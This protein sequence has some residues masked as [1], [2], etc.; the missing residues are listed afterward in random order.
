[1]PPGIFLF[2]TL[3]KVDAQAMAIARG[4]DDTVLVSDTSNHRVQRFDGRGKLL[5]AIGR[6]GAGRGELKFPQGIAVAPDTTLVVC[7]YGANRVSRFRQDGTFLG[8]FGE[9]GRAPGLFHSPRGVAVSDGGEV[10]VADTE[11]HRIQRFPLGALA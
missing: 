9:S 7:E 11:N 10:F 8:V 4:A 3:T 5:A 6:P 1:M 2:K